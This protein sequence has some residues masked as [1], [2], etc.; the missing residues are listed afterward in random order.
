MVLDFLYIAPDNSDLKE[1]EIKNL[2]EYIAA[3]EANLSSLN[4]KEREK[5][6]KEIALKKKEVEA[7]RNDIIIKKAE[8]D[9][10]KA[11]LAESQKR[12]FAKPEVVEECEELYRKWKLVRGQL[13]TNNMNKGIVQKKVQQRKKED[14]TDKCEDLIKEIEEI[15]KLIVQTEKDLDTLW[16]TLKVSYSKV[17]NIVHSTVPVSDNED[18]NK[19]ERTWGTIP[20]IKVDGKPG[21]AHHHQIL[22]WID[23]YETTDIAG[24]KGYFLKGYGV[25]LNQAL[26]QY[27][28]AFLNRRKYTPVQPPLFLKKEVMTETCQLSDFEESLY[29][30]IFY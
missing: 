28:L 7:K 18:N 16:S 5:K 19:I 9:Q 30:Y 27:G 20:N 29:K 10:K 2:E 25:L 22:R 1:K 14:K 11:E 23:G 15:D 12:R 3:Q 26:L 4:D 6:E 8:L 17:G 13:D 21:S 24:H